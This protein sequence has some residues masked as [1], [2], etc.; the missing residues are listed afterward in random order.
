MK[1]LPIILDVDTGVDDT[2]AILI[3]AQS[4][5]LNLIACAP[6]FG[7]TTL[8]HAIANTCNALALCGRFDVP[9]GRGAAFPWKKTLR[10]SPHIHGVNGIGEY[11]Y[12]TQHLEGYTG[13]AAWDLCYR[14]ILEQGDKVTYVALGPLTNLANLLKKHPD[15]KPRLER[16][17]YMGGDRRDFS[18][19]SQCASVN[20]YHDPDAAAYVFETGIP[21]Y[22]FSGMDATARV[23]VRLD[24][25]EEIFDGS[26]PRDSALLPMVK[27]Y[28]TN[29]GRASGYPAE[30]YAIHDTTTVM[31]LLCPE[32]YESEVCHCESEAMGPET[33]G[34]T[35]IDLFNIGNW[36][37]K[38]KQTHYMLVRPGCERL[39]QK[40]MLQALRF[41]ACS[42][43]PLPPM[44]DDRAGRSLTAAAAELLQECPLDTPL[45][46]RELAAELNKALNQRGDTLR[47]KRRGSRFL[48]SA[49]PTEKG[50]ANGLLAGDGDLHI[51]EAGREYLQ[52]LLWE[53]L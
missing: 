26:S 24:K 23:K 47:E 40:A 35:Q 34:F 14:R 13:E 21:F 19:G 8:E 29:C 22:M 33:I 52:K 5:R 27:A 37:L 46:P 36:R 30:E 51:T 41:G 17:L 32:Y 20:I 12:P 43:E 10:T 7:N 3:A 11:E 50:E 45:S 44:P 9:V 42:P 6:T 1:K 4:E 53:L 39:L 2:C 25:L 28:F 38:D 49:H 31:Y 18:G 48:F 16:V 15:V